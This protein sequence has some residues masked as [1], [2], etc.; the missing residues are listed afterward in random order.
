MLFSVL[1]MTQRLGD[2]FGSA[3]AH[4]SPVAFSPHAESQ[5]L[6]WDYSLEGISHLIVWVHSHMLS[7]H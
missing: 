3:G 4:L 1:A 6:P 5:V 2:H 7:L